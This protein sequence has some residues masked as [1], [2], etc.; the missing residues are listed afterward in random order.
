MIFYKLFDCLLN[1]NYNDGLNIL[2]NN[3]F[4]KLNSVDKILHKFMIIKD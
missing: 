2:I 4:I 1:K 3:V